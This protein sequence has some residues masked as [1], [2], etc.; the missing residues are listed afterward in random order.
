VRQLAGQLNRGLDL[1][2]ADQALLDVSIRVR[3]AGMIGLPD[4]V[5][6][7]TA[8]LSPEDWELLNRHPVL[9][10]EIL[11]GLSALADAAEIVR[12]HHERWDG[13]G[14]PEGRR[15]QAI[16]LLSRVIATCDA[17]VAM[18][19]DRP[20]RRGVG[21]DAALE[22]VSR[23]RGSQFDP[24]VVDALR[25]VVNADGENGTGPAP[26]A[27]PPVQRL[28][29]T[30]RRTDRRDLTTVIA[31]FDLVPAFVP[32]YERL[33]AA[34]AAST[35]VTRE[36]I[37]TIQTDLGLTVAVLRRAQRLGGRRGIANVADA[38][39]A[40]TPGEIRETI[41]PLPRAEFPWRSS[42]L[43]VLLQRSR[44]HAQAVTRAAERLAREAG[45]LPSEDLLASA[46]LHDIG[47]LVLGR[48][49]VDYST[50]IDTEAT[51]PEERLRQEQR[52]LGLDH[53]T[54]GAL[55]LRRWGLPDRLASTVADHHTS[56]AGNEIATYVRLADMVVHHSQG[57]RV[58]GKIMLR[59]GYACGLH[60]KSLINML[61]DLPHA[62][63]SERRRAE[64]S[65]LSERETEVLR[66]L[67]Q[68]KV[69]KVI[70]QELG[71]S[72]STVR[73]HLHG[74]YG[75]LDVGDRAQAVLRAT[76]MAWI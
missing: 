64:P 45:Q 31:E 19:L 7:S 20:H 3:D 22:H 47:K 60:P 29:R 37:A 51:S 11:T 41:E 16:P 24:Q 36:I 54:V 71:L 48:A 35:T 27:G 1:D 74:A 39:L 5:V 46:F 52:T 63:G 30:G 6:L 17:F 15:G 65:P 25:A 57:E 38:A 13:D 14:Y 73:S 68:G 44:V 75:K 59:L 4:R 28:A 53:A 76:Q 34:T 62:G 12:F 61:F 23:A 42:Q 32:A 55:L 66:K 69:Y 33:L 40:L 8:P 10:A 2:P 21:V 58:N 56:E 67:A 72:T 50:V 18:A 49:H 70:A 9:G 43:G 26:K